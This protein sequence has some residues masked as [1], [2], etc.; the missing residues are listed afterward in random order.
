M[1]VTNFNIMSTA[2]FCSKKTAKGEKKRA[3]KAA[4]KEAK[5]LKKGSRKVHGVPAPML[6]TYLGTWPHV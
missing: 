5:A 6:S 1:L 2:F 4:K 3:K